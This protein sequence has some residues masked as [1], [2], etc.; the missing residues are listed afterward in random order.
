VKQINIRIKRT[1]SNSTVSSKCKSINCNFINCLDST[2]QAN[3]KIKKSTKGFER[4]KRSI[5]STNATLQAINLKLKRQN[6]TEANLVKR[7]TLEGTWI[8]VRTGKLEGYRRKLNV[9]ATA[10]NE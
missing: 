9:M 2:F 8:N 1:R 7:F 4:R 3:E 6:S 10:G 5:I